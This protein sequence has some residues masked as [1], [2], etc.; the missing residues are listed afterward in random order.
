[1]AAQCSGDSSG[2]GSA[3]DKINDCL[4]TCGEL[5]DNQTYTVAPEAELY[6]G[7]HVQCR[8][9]HASNATQADTERHCQHALGAS[10]CD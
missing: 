5:E 7:D 10:P 9:F 2:S 8:I 4:M 3:E 6:E 1:V